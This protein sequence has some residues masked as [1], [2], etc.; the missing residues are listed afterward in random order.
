M[1]ITD[2][3]VD[4]ADRS[5]TRARQTLNRTAHEFERLEYLLRHRGHVVSREMLTLEVWKEA[6]RDSGRDAADDP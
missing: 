1:R 4:V 6:G 5:V 3:E 2:L